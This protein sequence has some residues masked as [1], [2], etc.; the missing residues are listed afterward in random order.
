[1]HQYVADYLHYSDGFIHLDLSELPTQ[2]VITKLQEEI[3]KSVA[4]QLDKKKSKPI[5]PKVEVFIPIK[6]DNEWDSEEVD[7]YMDQK[8]NPATVSFRE[9]FAFTSDCELL[10]QFKIA[11]K[12]GEKLSPSQLQL[13]NESKV[14]GIKLENVEKVLIS[15]I[16]IFPYMLPENFLPK[17]ENKS[18]GS[19]YHPGS[20]EVGPLTM[21]ARLHDYGDMEYV[22]NLDT[23]DFT[24]EEVYQLVSTYFDCV[25]N[26]PRVPKHS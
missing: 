19:S 13:L 18:M 16:G 14:G 4:I 3:T 11:Y 1:M 6:K 22:I 12:H 8:G 10:D 20:I 7:I 15:P 9:K 21:N 17:I 25:K 2:D 24:K 5:Y 23:T 26:F